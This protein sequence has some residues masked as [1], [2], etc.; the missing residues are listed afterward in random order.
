MSITSLDL[1]L[2]RVLDAVLT[3]GSVSRAARRLHVTPSA[4]SNALARLRTLVGDRLI[5]KKGRGIVP[6]PRALELAPVLAKS[7]RDLQHAIHGG[8]FN[9]AMTTR[10]FTIALSD[11]NQ[12]VLLPRIASLFST[13]LP[14]ARLRAISIDSVAP[15]GGL[16]GSELDVVIGPHAGGEDI[17][18]ELLVDQPTVLVCRRDHPIASRRRSRDMMATL[19]HVAVEM[20][21]G[22]NLRDMTDAAYSAAGVARH[23][24]MTVPSFMCAAAVAAM[25]NFVATVPEPLY[26]AVGLTLRLRTIPAPIPPFSVPMKLCWHERTHSDPAAAAFRELV[27][28]AATTTPAQHD[29]P[30]VGPQVDAGP[31]TASQVP[32]GRG[33]STR[34]KRSPAKAFR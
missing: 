25:T 29:T 1:N 27:R 6:T 30:D 24:V 19:Q 12:L 8:A 10:S 16:A 17:H 34:A 3:E 13:V 11:A 2:L 33:R 15:L 28:R 7:L 4:V 22:K 31:V 5:T 14:R 9:P 32:R 26:D 18:A 21:P 23:V 20:A